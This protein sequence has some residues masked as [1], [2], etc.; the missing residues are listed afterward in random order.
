MERLNNSNRYCVP[1]LRIVV[2][3]EMLRIARKTSEEPDRNGM[4][5]IKKWLTYESAV[6]VK[7]NRV[8]IRLVVKEMVDGK[9]F[10]DRYEI[11]RPA[12]MPEKM[13]P[14]STVLDSG[15]TAG[16]N[17]TSISELGGEVKGKE[18]VQAADRDPERQSARG[19]TS[20]N[21]QAPGEAGWRCT[22]GRSRGTSW[23]R[24]KK[25]AMGAADR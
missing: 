2:L 6:D 18:R 23:Q 19:R 24:C 4:K 16:L 7:G 17:E 11:S 12:V 14:A 25:A 8:G 3:P 21:A 5:E 15:G 22:P 1:G 10:Y 13:S 9:K 20:S